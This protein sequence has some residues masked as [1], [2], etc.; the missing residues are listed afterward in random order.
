VDQLVVAGSLRRRRES[1]GDL[2]ILATSTDPAKVLDAFTALPERTEIKMKGPTKATILVTGGIQVDFRVVEPAAFGAAWQYFTGSKEHNV[3]LRSL[4]KDRGLKVNEYGVF[5]GDERIAGVTEAEVY[6]AFGLAWVPPE[7]R[8]GRGEIAAAGAGTLPKLVEEADILGDL[9]IHLETVDPAA[10]ESAVSQA[11]ER[12]WSY[13]GLIPPAGQLDELRSALVAP[14]RTGPRV[15]VG[16]EVDATAAAAPRSTA[17][18]ELLRASSRAPGPSDAST[19]SQALLLTHLA[20]GPLGGVSDPARAAGWLKFARARRVA[21]ELT[22]RGAAEGVD[23]AQARAHTEAGGSVHVSVGV[24]HRSVLVLA[25]GLAR[26]AGLLSPQVLNAAPAVTWGTR[27][28][29]RAPPPR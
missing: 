11:R 17:D 18:Y 4:A 21:I 6:G 23:P 10:V 24:S 8:E 16:D 26:R 1:V 29:H 15:F 7:I 27:L 3:E 9:H 13:V 2:D 14:G 25:V 28:G 5:R 20:T 22:A 12:G 19:S